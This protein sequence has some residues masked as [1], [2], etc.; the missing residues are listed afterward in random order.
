MDGNIDVIDAQTFLKGLNKIIDIKSIKKLKILLYYFN[1]KILY[2]DY[3]SPLS[4]LIPV[5]LFFYINMNRTI[6]D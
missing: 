3:S 4:K 5:T 2:L 1:P 6:V